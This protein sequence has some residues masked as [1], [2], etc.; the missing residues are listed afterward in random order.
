MPF[1]PFVCMCMVCMA[2]VA[3]TCVWL[4]DCSIA[5]AITA[6]TC[7]PE[8]L[9]IH[10]FDRLSNSCFREMVKNTLIPF[11]D[12]DE[13]AAYVDIHQDSSSMKVLVSDFDYMAI[14]GQGGFGRVVHARKKSTGKHFAMKI[15]PKASLIEEHGGNLANLHTEKTVFANCNHPFVV[16]M[17]YAVQT[18]S[19]AIL[20]LSLVDGGDLNDL[21]W[22]APGGKLTEYHGRIYAAQIGSALAHLHEVGVLFRDLKPENVLICGMTGNC[23]LTDM[24]LAAPIVVTEEKD[25]PEKLAA[26]ATIDEKWKGPEL[27]KS[28][29]RRASNVGGVPNL[30][31]LS[32]RMSIGEDVEVVDAAAQATAFAAADASG[33]SETY[34]TNAGETGE[35]ASTELDAKTV[36]ADESEIHEIAESALLEDVVAKEIRRGSM[37]V[38][39]AALDEDST[40]KILMELEKLRLNSPRGEKD[41][42]KMTEAEVSRKRIKRM[43]VVG[44]RGYMAPEIVEG[45]VLRRK[46]RRGYNE[47]VDWFALGVTVFVMLTGYQPFNDD[48]KGHVDP[49][50]LAENFPRDSKGI[51]RRPSG[52]ATLLQVVKFPAKMSVASCAFCRELLHIQP[53]QRLGANGYDEIKHHEWF[54]EPQKAMPADMRAFGNDD[55][56]PLSELEPMHEDA[57]LQDEYKV[58]EWV[59]KTARSKALQRVYEPGAQPK[60]NHFEHIMATFD[61]R[62]QRRYVEWYSPPEAKEQEIFDS[63]DFMSYGALKDELNAQ[64]DPKLLKKRVPRESRGT[65]KF[66]TNKALAQGHQQF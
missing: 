63:W 31:L 64:I 42:V 1:L 23:K 39:H 30:R 32:K 5:D 52:F 38:Q 19:H 65:A 27:L 17:C 45:K 29:P 51:L 37:M 13:Y 47:T 20:V 8:D 25:G 60:Y 11:K 7:T 3:H 14:L 12:S 56:H 49:K 44:T 62:D 15:Q 55:V 59:Y 61:I 16:D 9:T 34:D 53:A 10:F 48:D 35:T 24:G 66:R 54:V 41:V 46:E 40:V 21:L 50:V 4:T 58:P 22:R 57:L 18:P 33:G 6:H 2:S 28:K 36:H 26:P 43:S